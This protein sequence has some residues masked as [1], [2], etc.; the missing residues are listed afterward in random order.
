MGQTVSI[1]FQ[2]DDSAQLAAIV[3]DR[4][5]PQ[6][7]FLRATVLQLAQQILATR[8]RQLTPIFGPF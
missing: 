7:H 3:G 6:K 4:N 8:V 5:R 2:A 1:I